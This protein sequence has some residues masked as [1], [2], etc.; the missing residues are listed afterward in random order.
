MASELWTDE[1]QEIEEALQSGSK[2]IHL[3]SV[4]SK[5]K[6]FW[7]L[8]TLNEV[9]KNSIHLFLPIIQKYLL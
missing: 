6:P 1:D 2:Y 3:I 4:A 7:V 8:N 9:I 5:T